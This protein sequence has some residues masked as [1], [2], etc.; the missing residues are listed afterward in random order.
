MNIALSKA[1]NVDVFEWL[2]L[3]N[4]FDHAFSCVG[5]YL[6]ETDLN[7][8]LGKLKCVLIFDSSLISIDWNSTLEDI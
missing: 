1:E 5:C 4:T 6:T 7:K 3:Q 8:Q 2:I